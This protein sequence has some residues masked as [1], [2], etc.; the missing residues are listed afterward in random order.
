[1]N[2]PSSHHLP[3]SIYKHEPLN[4]TKYKTG[5]H[6]HLESN[7][8][9]ASPFPFLSDYT[10]PLI[11]LYSQSVTDLLKSLTHC[12][13]FKFRLEFPYLVPH[14]LPYLQGIESRVRFLKVFGDIGH[15]S[16]GAGLAVE[17]VIELRLQE[18][19]TAR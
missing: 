9:L 16:L 12:E 2:N 5:R 3:S 6:P 10:R 1:M 15:T 18:F 11:S 8:L 17:D 4:Y 14:H 7:R 19:R 13:T